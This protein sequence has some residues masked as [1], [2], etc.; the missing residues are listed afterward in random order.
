[1]RLIEEKATADAGSAGL[2]KFAREHKSE[3]GYLDVAVNAHGAE[4]GSLMLRALARI[5]HPRP[6]VVEVGPGGGAA[7]TY[8]AGQLAGRLAGERE[9][10]LTLIEAPGVASRALAGAIDAFNRVGVCELRSGFAHDIGELLPK[11][12]DVIS[13]SALMHEVYSYSGGYSGLHTMMRTLPRVLTPGGFFA[14][15]DVYGVRGATLHERVT[16]SYSSRAWLMFLRLF[17]QQYLAEGTHPYHRADDELVARQ[18][19]RIVAVSD[20][21]PGTC[22]VICAPIGLF[23]EIQRHYITLRDHVW[24]SGVLGIVPELDGDLAADWI[25]F[26]AGHK[27]VHF[28]VGDEAEWLPGP[29]R[30]MLPAM[31]EPYLDHRTIDGD[32]FDSVTEVALLA[33]LNAVESG[34]RACRQVWQKW[35]LREGRETYAYLTLDQ[36]LCAFVVHSASAGT[37]T[38]L[39]PVQDGDISRVDRHYYNRFLNK[40]LANPLPDAKQLVLLRNVPRGD[41]ATMSQALE[42][43]AG[44]CGKSSLARMYTAI[45][46]GDSGT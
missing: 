16:Q 24:R 44:Q 17:T 26:R 41:A 28:R 39:M 38:V 1:M 4:K 29:H 10:R 36:L 32:I 8:L 15:R 27:R 25:D 40:Q 13:A 9:V 12:V 2:R 42:A 11:P 34:D 21:D 30:M 5:E 14:Y 35:L 7:V 3:S 46:K 18:N 19:S 33:F 23:R 37:D 43:V 6:Q 20:L 45:N 22:A 31:S